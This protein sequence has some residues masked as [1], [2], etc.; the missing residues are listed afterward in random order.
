MRIFRIL[1][2]VRS[3]KIITD[4]ILERRAHSTML[5]A[6]LVTITI[7]IVAAISILHF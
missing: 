4:F 1:R 2:G 6:A 5:A 3:A 7:I